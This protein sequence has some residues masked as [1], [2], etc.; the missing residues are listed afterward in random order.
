MREQRRRK[1][2]AAALS[3]A[4]PAQ[5]RSGRSIW[6]RGLAFLATI[7]LGATALFVVSAPAAN[8]QQLSEPPRVLLLTAQPSA[9]ASVAERLQTSLSASDLRPTGYYLP[10]GGSVSLAVAA[11]PGQGAEV[12]VGSLAP[13]SGS[14]TKVAP[15]VSKLQSGVNSIT[16][17]AGGILYFKVVGEVGALSVSI[18]P[19]VQPMPYYI[20]GTTTEAAF[21]AQLDSRTT[22]FVEFVGRNVLLTVQR[23]A[24]LTYRNEDH[25]ELMSTYAEIVKLQWSESG[26]SGN[27]GLNAEPKNRYHFVAYPEAMQGIGAFATHGYMGFPLPIQNRLLTVQGLRTSGWGPYHELGHQMQQVNYKPTALTE[28]TVNI[29]SLAVNREFAKYGQLPRLFTPEKDTGAAAWDSAIPKI[30]TAG[31]DYEKTFKSMEKLVMFEQL[32]LSFDNFWPR[33]HKLV[34]EE[35]PDRGSFSDTLYRQSTLVLYASKT[36]NADLTGFFARWGISVN[37]ES[38]AKIASLGL[39][40]PAADPTLTRDPEGK[41]TYDRLVAARG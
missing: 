35:K 16:D 20:E 31:V 6:R 23:S 34:R 38:A 14:N 22:P 1:H 11:L 30:G 25:A 40:P 33:L 39:V 29:Y 9:R 2:L 27:S 3:G 12:V 10:A 28:V 15:R 7:G 18:G 37:A 36:A 8:A 24:A 21:Q 5:Q 32:R 41:A 19:G 4:N 13:E 26:I 17:E